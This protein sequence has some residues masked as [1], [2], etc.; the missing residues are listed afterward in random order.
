MNKSEVKEFNLNSEKFDNYEAAL[1]QAIIMNV[2]KKLIN[3]DGNLTNT[4]VDKVLLDDEELNINSKHKLI[5]IDSGG[6]RSIEI[7][8]YYKDYTLRIIF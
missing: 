2:E 4:P 8:Q 5:I 1:K 6:K 3:S 7:P